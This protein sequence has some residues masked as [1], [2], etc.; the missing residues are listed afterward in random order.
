N[1]SHTHA[2]TP[3]QA[4]ER[5]THVRARTGFNLVRL[6]DKWVVSEVLPDTPAETAGVKAGWIVV[7]LNG[8]PVGATFDFRPKEGESARWEFLDANDRRVLLSPVARQLST[9]ARQIARELD[10]GFW[11]LRFDEFDGKDRRWLSAQLKAHETAPGVVI[12]LRRN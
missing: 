1:D 7:S 3:A 2:L 6:D 5:K 8:E 11:Y 12:D 4:T 10:G 9:A